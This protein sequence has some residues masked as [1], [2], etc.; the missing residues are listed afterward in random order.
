MVARIQNLKVKIWRKKEKM[1]SEDSDYFTSLPKTYEE[2]E[3]FVKKQ[4]EWGVVWLPNFK[5]Y[6]N[7]DKRV[8]YAIQRYTPPEASV[9]VYITKERERIWC[10]QKKTSENK[11]NIWIGQYNDVIG[12]G[13]QVDYLLI[14]NYKL[15]DGKTV[16][17]LVQLCPLAK[18]ILFR[19]QVTQLVGEIWIEITSMDHPFWNALCEE[20]K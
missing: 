5:K 8:F 18:H 20:L 7:S 17:T 1:S 6:E 19:H 14:Y 2:I 3:P 4:L 11:R 12:F 16:S 9:L 15:L 13:H 10:K